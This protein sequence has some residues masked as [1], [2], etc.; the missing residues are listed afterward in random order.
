M[1]RKNRS[2]EENVRREKIR[3]LLQ[4]ANIDSTPV[5]FDGD[6]HHAFLLFRLD[7]AKSEQEG[8]ERHR[9]RFPFALK[10]RKSA[11]QK[12]T[13]IKMQYSAT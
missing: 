2:P 5:D 10:M 11:W 4:M 1:T 9:G 3:E 12:A 13:R 8:G 6:L 7:F